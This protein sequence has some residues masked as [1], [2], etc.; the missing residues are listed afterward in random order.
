M[1]FN[2]TEGFA[3][4]WY[5]DAGRREM[6]RLAVKAALRQAQDSLTAVDPVG[7]AA[8]RPACA[9]SRNS[10]RGGWPAAPFR[11]AWL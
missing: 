7:T 5:F 2:R 3:S 4:K 11:P 8:G 1:V 9:V 10:L 6:L